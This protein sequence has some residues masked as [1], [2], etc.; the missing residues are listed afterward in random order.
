MT[1]LS[2]LK[3][4]VEAEA[5]DYEKEGI[6]GLKKR[7]EALTGY[8]RE[9]ADRILRVDEIHGV[10]F[11]PPEMTSLILK[12]FGP[13]GLER[14]RRQ[15]IVRVDNLITREGALFNDLRALR[16]IQAAESPQLED[17]IEKGRENDPFSSPLTMT[18]E[19][20]FGRVQGRYSITA[21][22]IAKYDAN[23]GVVIFNEFHP[24]HFSEEEV[25]D[26]FRTVR[27]YWLK[28][29][30]QD[31][32]AMY[33]F[34]TWNC[35]WKSAASMVHGHMQPT[36]ARG[37][38]YAG[39]ERLREDAI[40]YRKDNNGANYFTD[41]AFLYEKLGLVIKRNGV[42]IMSDLTPIKEKGI[43][44]YAEDFN[45]DLSREISHLLD[46]YINRLGVRSFNLI[47]Y[48]PPLKEVSEEDWSDYPWVIHVVDRGD[49]INPTTDM[50]G[51]E[52]GGKMPVISADP[53]KVHAALK[54]LI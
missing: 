43:K 35:L 8:E 12:Q 14:V 34:S 16:P 24:L 47:M 49:P 25:V 52:I 20:G 21:S 17:L 53:Y 45:D 41:E 38:H 5:P 54:S 19:D 51:L 48:G 6:F 1:S 22:N 31:S 37:R 3:R 40:F 26:Y 15:K 28:S 44:I 27:G 2:E 4:R 23:H 39:P 9:V 42:V 50:G 29:H 13:N 10:A 46:C 32:E 30:E 11:P 7:I 18:P 36:L 33:P